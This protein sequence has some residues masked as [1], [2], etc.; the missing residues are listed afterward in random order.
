MEED[1][2]LV[3]RMRDEAS[4]VLDKFEREMDELGH[5]TE[6]TSKEMKK[7]NRDFGEAEK[8]AKRA[9]QEV[10]GFGGHTK[11]A[12]KQLL[13]FAGGAAAFYAIQRGIR[14]SVGEFATFEGGLAE[15]RKTAGLTGEDLEAMGVDVQMLTRDI[16]VAQEKL[17]DFAATAGRAGLTGRDEL[18]E[19]AKTAA[20]LEVALG[21]IDPESLMRF[22]GNTRDGDDVAG[23]LNKVAAALN[24]LDDTSKTTASRISTMATDVAAA[25]SMFDLASEDVLAWSTVL[26]ETGV[27]SGIAST[28][29]LRLGLTIQQASA[30]G[31]EKLQALSQMVG[32][33]GEEFKNVA[34]KDMGEA[35]NL[36]LEGMSKLD[37][38]SREGALELFD[39]DMIQARKAINPLLAKI[40][41]VKERRA[42]AFGRDANELK[43]IAEQEA[44]LA[45]F[46]SQMQLFENAVNEAKTAVGADFADAIAPLV[47]IAKDLVLAFVDWYNTLDEGEQKLVAFGVTGT[48]ALASLLAMAGKLGVGMA[49]L[50]IAMGGTAARGLT[51]AKAMLAFAG[52]LGLV[53]VAV[54]G[55]A[56]GLYYLSTRNELVHETSDEAAAA[57]RETE[58]A[59][60]GAEQVIMDLA[61]AQ[62][63]QAE[64][65]RQA[66]IEEREL[67]KERLNAARAAWIQ[68]SAEAALLEARAADFKGSLATTDPRFSSQSAGA[69]AAQAAATSRADAAA[70]AK[71][72]QI[73]NDRLDKLDAALNA[74]LE[75][76]E[77]A[78]FGGG[79][80][81]DKKGK[82]AGGKSDAEKELEDRAK[83]HAQ[84]R[85][86]ML[87]NLDLLKAIEEVQGGNSRASRDARIG[88]TIMARDM[89]E[90]LE[91]EQ[92]VVE[93][94]W[95]LR[96]RQ[97]DKNPE[98]TA[99]QLELVKL[100]E[101]EEKAIREKVRAEQELNNT[102]GSFDYLDE[103]TAEESLQWEIVDVLQQKNLD[104]E[105]E[106]ELLKEK[107]RLG[108][109]L[110]PDEAA[111]V[112]GRVD[113]NRARDFAQRDLD[114]S[115]E[116]DAG[117][118]RT[119]GLLQAGFADTVEAE[120]ARRIAEAQADL[121]AKKGELARLSENEIALIREQT[122]QQYL[123]NDA[124][125]EYNTKRQMASEFFD[126]ISDGITDI[127]K[128]QVSIQDGIAGILE[129]LADMVW[130]YGVLIPLQREFMQ[131]FESSG[132]GGGGGLFGLLGGLIGGA[133]GGGGTTPGIT[134]AEAMANFVPSFK[135]GGIMTEWGSIPLRKYSKGGIANSP[136]L[137]MFGEGSVPEAYVPVPSG[138]IPVEI[139]GGMGGGVT[140]HNSYQIVFEEGAP[141]DSDEIA[142]KISD[143]VDKQTTAT[144]EKHLRPGG[145][146]YEKQRGR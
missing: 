51:G 3:M 79:G 126:T 137:A 107:Q 146:I 91:E 2:T 5:A 106:I 49:A 8:L 96:Q 37:A 27:E 143:Q 29:F 18:K 89:V 13:S 99:A 94:T 113:A 127:V 45:K 86:E 19:F 102:R 76:P 7:M 59:A 1:L 56:G 78:S 124:I 30:L 60:A 71:Q 82:G 110:T 109:N 125:D 112:E 95:E 105:K 10:K 33:T 20:E 134:G 69:G 142:R 81:S 74:P 133:V 43:W 123:L 53:G 120:T 87:K 98:M 80:G 54:A 25:G 11:D 67:T 103:L 140:I 12:T 135:D 131:L 141:D 58:E 34:E 38:K 16:P 83:A 15:I 115:R 139:N 50:N 75:T 63:A 121:I 104:H 111:A 40:D 31:G 128:G 72:V 70:A 114:A 73:L 28:T 88:D 44:Q 52:R 129:G 24:M 136:Q 26:A 42:Q 68:A 39:L 47:E 85:A 21:G 62:G 130:Q 9:G 61:T 116:R 138:K 119:A 65:A 57:L 101:A 84:V 100:T 66:A 6:A 35:I 92:A 90:V 14:A 77:L 36:V 144:I 108:R 41:E 118:A 93:A 132:S 117:R 122:E 64:E 48:A 145:M 4:K 97:L 22:I 17:L 23:N 55:L 32:M 46:S